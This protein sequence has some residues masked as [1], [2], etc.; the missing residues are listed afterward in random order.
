MFSLCSPGGIGLKLEMAKPFQAELARLGETLAWAKDVDVARLRAAVRTS[1]LGPLMAVG[2][3]GSF[4]GAHALAAIHKRHAQR[5]ATV[6]TPLDLASAPLDLTTSVWLMS[7]GGS[8]V[9]IIAAA[10][11]AICAEPRQVAVLSGKEA[12]PL[13]DLCRDHG[14][15]DFLPFELPAGKDGFLA[16]NSLFGFCCLLTRAYALEFQQEAEWLAAAVQLERVCGEASDIVRTWQQECAPLWDRDTTVVLHGIHATLGAIDLESKFTEAALGNLHVSDYRNFAH[17]RHHWLAKRGDRSG[18][19]ALISLDD[20]ALATKTLALI[21]ND[22]PVARIALEGAPSSV[23]LESLVAAYWVSAWAGKA[24]GIDPGRPGVPEFG[25]KIYHLPL[26]KPRTLAHPKTRDEAAIVRKAGTPLSRLTSEE[27]ELWKRA[28]SA[29][30]SRLKS[31]EFGGLI[32][33][34]DGTLVDTR[35]RFHPPREPIKRELIRLLD[36]G[37]KVGMATGR[38]VSVR[39]DLRAILPEALWEN[40]LVGYYNGAEIA[41]L[42]DDSTP[43]GGPTLSGDLLEI[44]ALLRANPELAALAT[45]TDRKWQITLQ[46]NRPIPENRLW[47]IV[48]QIVLLTTDAGVVVTRS[49]H[50]IDIVPAS[51]SKA[52]VLTRLTSLNPAAQ[53]LTVGDRGRWPGNDYVLLRSPFALSVDEVSVDPDTCWNLSRPGQRGIASTLEYLS[54]LKVA[55]AKAQFAAEALL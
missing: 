14:Y 9:D 1:G 35:D 38:G 43:D 27:V 11:A 40:V 13:A 7:A 42:T 54:A 30:R 15:V 28:L 44:A 53:V 8:N 47:D 49:S 16:T 20:E 12:S 36:G 21:P 48:Q 34:Y 2:S 4:S 18:I 26:P 5:I 52:D 24:R 41:A 39:R 19:I 3:G 33:D 32:L 25:R 55:D 45:Q 23:M 29:F 51:K 17:G 22:I 46:P 10:K 37:L 31:A 6:A 50:S